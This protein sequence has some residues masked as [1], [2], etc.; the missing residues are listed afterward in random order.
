MAFLPEACDYV[1]ESKAETLS[2]A[3]PL[4]GDVMKEFCSLA[5]ENEIW[6]SVGGIH[7]QVNCSVAEFDVYFEAG[8][9]FGIR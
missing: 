7:E 4:N 6:L 1:G 9:F 2:M 5:K 8:L 3:E